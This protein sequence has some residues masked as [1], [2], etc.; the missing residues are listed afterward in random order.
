MSKLLTIGLILLISYHTSGMTQESAKILSLSQALEIGQKNNLSLQQGQQRIEQYTAKVQAQ[1]S[2]YFPK[3][4]ASGLYNHITDI[5]DINLPGFPA[6]S[7]ANNVDLYDLSL[8][9]QQPIFTGFR[10]SNLLHSAKEELNSSQAQY[11]TEVNGISYQIISVYRSA[12]LNLLQ[13][14]VL[15]SS[16][17]RIQN[18]LKSTLQFYRAG[19]TSAFDTLTM[20]NQYLKIQTELNELNHHYQILLTQLE[21]LLNMSPVEGVEEFSSTE[22]MPDLPPLEHFLQVAVQHRSELKQVKYQY[23]AQRYIKKSMASS[24]WPHMY[25]QITFHYLKPDVDILRTEW[26]DF[27]ILGVNLQ[28]DLWDSG[29]RKQEIRQLSHTLNILSLEEQKVIAKI[30]TEVKQAYQNLLTD[31]DQFRL[32]KKLVQQEQ[33]RYRIAH[34][35]Y[36]QGLASAVELSNAE[37]ALT[38]AELRQ[39]ETVI[40]WWLDRSFMDYTTGRLITAGE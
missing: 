32:S 9:L 22:I 34:Q 28:W 10:V 27:F 38:T 29:R 26:T 31:L 24:Y 13:Q 7:T 2:S 12:Q 30:Q 39:E 18:D 20:A 15:K 1:K 17:Q 40:K 19:Q 11:L 3:L 23:Q 36:K 5:P 6:T 14:K 16:L 25:G 8:K 4:A 21:F 37:I 33:E 35:K